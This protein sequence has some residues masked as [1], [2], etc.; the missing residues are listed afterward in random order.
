M[1]RLPPIPLPRKRGVE[2]EFQPAESLIARAVVPNAKR[3]GATFS[4]LGARNG[5]HSE[6]HRPF[7]SFSNFMIYRAGDGTRTHD[8]QLR[9]LTD[10]KGVVV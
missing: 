4:S 7:L 10:A 2:N 1:R 8:V 6:E 3:P 9:K 5:P